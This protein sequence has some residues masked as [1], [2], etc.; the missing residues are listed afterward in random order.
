M[1]IFIETGAVNVSSNPTLFHP[2][3]HTRNIFVNPA[4][5][6][7]VTGIIDWQ[8]AAIEPAF[9]F[10]ANTPDFAEELPYDE[11]L[12][13]KCSTETDD[14]SPQARLRADVEFFVNTWAVML[15]I[16]PKLR[17][18]SALDPLILRFLAAGSIGWLKDPISIRLLL[19]DI[20]ENW[21]ELGLPGEGLYQ[22]SKEE[23]AELRRQEDVLQ[24]TQRLKVY[25]SRLLRCDTDGWVHNDRWE[26]VLPQYREQ[27]RRFLASCVESREEDE[28][29]AMELQRETSSGRTSSGKHERNA[30]QTSLQ[31]RPLPMLLSS[32]NNI[33]T[34]LSLRT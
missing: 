33:S 23:T 7:K 24:S 19:T 3:F 6:T 22:P 16:C 13:G 15:Q 17:E 10:A 5:S 8:C 18:A 14:Q 27:Y 28:D 34:S 32:D 31:D 9:V 4:D 26:E 11:D 20:G 30:R 25:L 2:D 1:E 29:E 12:D 21:E